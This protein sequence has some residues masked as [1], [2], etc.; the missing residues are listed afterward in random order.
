MSHRFAL[1]AG[2]A[3]LLLTAP[4]AAHHPGGVGNTGTAGPINTLSATTL[5]QGQVAIGFLYEYIKLGGLSDAALI[6]AAS[7]HIHAHSIGTIQSASAGLALGLTSDLMLLVR[8]PYV[9]RTDIREGHHEHVAGVAINSVDFRGDSDG[10]G[11]LTALAQ[12]RFLNNRTTGTEM[13]LLF[14]AKAPT[15]ATN[16]FDNQG[17]PFEA[18]FQP[19]SCAWDGL[20]GLAVTQRL[21]RWSLDGNVLYQWVGTGVQDTNLGDR[22]RY[23][24]AVSYRAI[25]WSDPNDPMNAHAHVV[26][27]GRKARHRHADHDHGPEP[28]PK[29]HFALDL[30]LELNG[31]WHDKQ[32]IAGVTDPNSGGNTVYVSPGVRAS[33]GNVS[34]FASLGIPIVN[35]L[36]G[37]QSKPDYRLVAGIAAGF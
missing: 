29:P 8:L 25:G 17:L 35:D 30:V 23:N 32:V 33:F 31:E 2:V 16:R 26:P 18:E 22:F 5:E 6:E 13:A 28:A 14:G 34:G 20:L 7:K 4:A 19:G 12:W 37:L 1:S 11:D 27:A 15:G 21:G 36:N 9:L 24:A 3:A 10:I